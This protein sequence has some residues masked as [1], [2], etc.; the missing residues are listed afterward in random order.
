MG[1]YLSKAKYYEEKIRRLHEH[2]IGPGYAEARRYLNE[3]SDLAKR[4]WEKDKT[5]APLIHGIMK[6]MQQIVDDMKEKET[7]SDVT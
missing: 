6:S 7:N 2:G 3:L 5:D 4:A 1:K